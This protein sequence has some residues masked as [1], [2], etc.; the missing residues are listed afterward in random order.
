MTGGGWLPNSNAMQRCRA[1]PCFGCYANARLAATRRVSLCT[2][3]RHIATWRAQFAGLARPV[4]WRSGI[5]SKNKV[6]RTVAMESTGVYWKA[7][8]FLKGDSRWCWPMRNTSSTARS[9]DRCQRLRVDRVDDIVKAAGVAKG[10][11][12]LYFSTKDDVVTAVAERMVVGVGE[13]IEALA[14]TPLLSP[15]ERLLALGQTMQEVGREP[16]DTGKWP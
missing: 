16:F 7:S 12:Y 5:G 10:T 4:C 8:I 1:R 13:R 11:F 3:Q 15:V 9:E 2:F 14:N 6:R